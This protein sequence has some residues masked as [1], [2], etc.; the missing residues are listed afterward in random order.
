MRTRFGFV[1][2]TEYVQTSP[3]IVRAREQRKLTDADQTYSA[4]TSSA[5]LIANS[6]IVDYGSTGSFQREA[7]TIPDS[8]GRA[9]PENSNDPKPTAPRGLLTQDVVIVLVNYAIFTSL[10]LAFDVLIPLMWSTSLEHGGLGFTPYKIGLT[11]CIYGVINASIQLSFLGRILKRFG[12]QRVYSASA[13]SLLLAFGGFPVAGFFAK[14]AGGADWKVW[15]VIAV[16]L[17]AQMMG[18]AAYGQSF[19][20]RSCRII[21]ITFY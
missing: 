18:C 17:F 4:P 1:T 9:P 15:T 14:R 12:P 16:Q 8:E 21:S 10:A 19:P 20:P 2:A 3:S 13:A 7:G 6:D 5:S 11:M